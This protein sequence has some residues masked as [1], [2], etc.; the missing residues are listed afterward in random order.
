MTNTASIQKRQTKAK[1]KQ[2]SYPLIVE[3]KLRDIPVHSIKITANEL[4]NIRQ[5]AGVPASKLLVP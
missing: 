3:V 4:E 5:K 1:R 2:I